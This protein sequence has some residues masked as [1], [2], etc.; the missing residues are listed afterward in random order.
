MK[1]RTILSIII[2]VVCI[3][4]TNKFWFCVNPLEISF[5]AQGAGDTKF[6]FFLN[7]E[8]NNDFKRVKYGVIEANLDEEDSIKLFINR[9]HEAKRVKLTISGISTPPRSSKPLS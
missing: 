1:K 5:N 7:K 9:V 6:E 3:A 4:L 8:D 2:T